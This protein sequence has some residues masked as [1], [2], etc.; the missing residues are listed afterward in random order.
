MLLRLAQ[1]RKTVVAAR[2]A[3]SA[4]SDSATILRE[5]GLIADPSTA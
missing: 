4:A 5:L 1:M 2:Q 3:Q